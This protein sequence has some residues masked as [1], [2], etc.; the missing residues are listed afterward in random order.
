MSIMKFPRTAGARMTSLIC[1][2]STCTVITNS[3][4]PAHL[5][6]YVNCLSRVLGDGYARF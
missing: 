5:W 3:T 6:K 2:Y 1:D 4:A